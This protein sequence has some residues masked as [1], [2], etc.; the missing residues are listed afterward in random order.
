MVARSCFFLILGLLGAGS[1]LVEQF[2]HQLEVFGLVV[3]ELLLLLAEAF[4]LLLVLSRPVAL[5][6]VVEVVEYDVHERVRLGSIALPFSLLGVRGKEPVLLVFPE[7]SVDFSRGLTF[8]SHNLS[9][10][11]ELLRSRLFLKEPLRGLED[12]KHSLLVDPAQTEQVGEVAVFP[13]GFAGEQDL[14]DQ[15]NGALGAVVE[16]ADD[17]FDELFLALVQL[18]NLAQDTIRELEVLQQFVDGQHLRQHF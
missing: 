2:V 12:F 4:D 5:G 10:E 14:G 8:E 15:G 17:L 1:E 13:L 16:V 11:L 6:A 3:L 9:L 7:L 18:V